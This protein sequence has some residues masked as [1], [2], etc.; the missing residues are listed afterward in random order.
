MMAKRLMAFRSPWFEFNLL[1]LSRQRSLVPLRFPG[2][3][4]GLVISD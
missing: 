4:K 3:A 1:H 2:N